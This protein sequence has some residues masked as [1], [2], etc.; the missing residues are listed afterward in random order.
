MRLSR[1]ANFAFA[2]LLLCLLA[3]SAG[4]GPLERASSD[5]PKSGEVD[6]TVTRTGPDGTSRTSTGKT[7]WK[8]GGG[9]WTRDTVHTGP[10]GK[11]STTHVDGQKTD[12]GYT[13]EATHTGPN[14]GVTTSQGQGTWDP[15]TKTWT[16]D[17]VV[18]HPNGS[19]S[20][21]QVT[22]TVT[23][24]TPEPPAAQ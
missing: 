19:T 11:Q 2:F 17:R 23:P 16:R 4:A 21:T 13:R 1:F 8:R 9:H 5:S 7:T 6:R 14:G 10:N 20:S 15:A 22:R 3:L 24:V 12:N 18:T